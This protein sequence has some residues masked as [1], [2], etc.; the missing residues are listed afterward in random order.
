M[1]S[2]KLVS[3]REI[4]DHLGLSPWTIYGMLKKE[5]NGIPRY[6]VG[7]RWFFDIAQVDEWIEENKRG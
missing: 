4:A 3:L 2:D 1:K 6:K 7:K 5:L